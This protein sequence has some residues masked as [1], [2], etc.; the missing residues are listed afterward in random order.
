M[1]EWATTF[2]KPIQKETLIAVGSTLESK[3]LDL[4]SNKRTVR[5]ITY[6]TKEEECKYLIKWRSTKRIAVFRHIRPKL[7]VDKPVTGK[8]S[9]SMWK[10][11][12]RNPFSFT[13]HA[14][15]QFFLY[16]Q[17]PTMDFYFQRGL[18]LAVVSASKT[19]ALSVL[20]AY[21]VLSCIIRLVDNGITL[22]FRNAKSPSFDHN[23]P[24]S[25]CSGNK[26]L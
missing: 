5:G 11:P 20:Y 22:L 19:H 16:M 17:P 21:F 2:C 15:M 7:T 1:L 18:H 10:L 13:K 25:Y 3:Q 9:H 24:F 14:C 26:K 12:V 23:F 8:S 6:S 4:Y